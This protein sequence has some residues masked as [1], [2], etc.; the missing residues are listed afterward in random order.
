MAAA[1]PQRDRP[2]QGLLDRHVSARPDQLYSDPAAAPAP[3]D[4]AWPSEDEAKAHTRYWA[5]SHPYYKDRLHESSFVFPSAVSEDE[6]LRL[7][8]DEPQ[9]YPDCP[10]LPGEQRDPG[11]V[12]LLPAHAKL[13]A[14]TRKQPCIAVGR[15][16][17]AAGDER[18]IRQSL[19]YAFRVI[20]SGVFVRIRGGK[21]TQFLP[22]TK[23]ESANRWGAGMEIAGGATP[24]QFVERYARQV[25]VPAATFEADPAK[26]M[27]T[28]GDTIGMQNWEG[29]TVNT[30]IAELC[31]L[32][33][34]TASEYRLPD[35]AFVFN[36]RDTPAVR[37]DPT[38]HPHFNVFDGFD[39]PLAA[40]EE[41]LVE[42]GSLPFLSEASLATDP[43]A[44][45]GQ[46]AD[47]LIPTQDDVALAT[48]LAFVHTGAR[49]TRPADREVAEVWAGRRATAVF[50]GSATGAGVT[51]VAAVG[52]APANYNQRLIAA[53]LGAERPDLLD[54]GVTSLNVRPR[55]TMGFPLDLVDR[56]RLTWR[57][58]R[59]LAP[60]EQAGHR[61]Q[62]Y[63]DGHSVAFRMPQLMLAGHLVL[64]VA[65]RH[66]YVAWWSPLLRP[67]VHYV[68][69]RADLGD[70][71][72]KIEWCRAND[73][74]AKKIAANGREMM[75]QLF[76]GGEP[77]G[78]PEGE[79]RHRRAAARSKYLTGYLAALLR[80]IAP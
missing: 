26:W 48:G 46:F 68:P 69:V 11:E 28:S 43:A 12:E 30:K 44:M 16:M 27:P 71:V 65:S 10:L 63:I 78:E 37:A 42:G 8:L 18:V 35:C 20:G 55:K 59:F 79:Q 58:A 61:Y 3:P 80:A 76:P 36:R 41:L 2:K 22:F 70:L 23:W 13:I 15:K 40:G 57:L 1:R 51:D 4:L 21:I 24:R 77:G 56:R 74:T 53:R 39:E 32:L 75:L 73:A 29:F 72:E 6:L 45:L 25:G 33:W 17:L 38:R 54:A 34:L 49:A 60:E 66:G 52:G 62:L 64:Y 7:A 31:Y 50:R 19:R 14:A 9:H 47:A 67:W 5:S